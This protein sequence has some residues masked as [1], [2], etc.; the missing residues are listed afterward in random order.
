MVVFGFSGAFK[1][2]VLLASLHSAVAAAANDRPLYVR[3]DKN[4]GHNSKA[5]TAH[6]IRENHLEK[7]CS[8]WL[9]HPSKLAPVTV[10][11]TS[12]KTQKVHTT[13]IVTKTFTI[14]KGTTTVTTDVT[15]TNDAT[16]RVVGTDYVTETDLGYATDVATTTVTSVVGTSTVTSVAAMET[17]V[18]VTGE[19][20]VV[21]TA[22]VTDSTTVT[23]TSTF[24]V[25][26]T[27]GLRAVPAKQRRNHRRRVPDCL[28]H[29]SDDRISEGC[30]S[31]IG[32]PKAGH[33]IT[34][35]IATTNI[36]STH[37]KTHTSFGGHVVIPKE[38]VTVTSTITQ[39]ATNNI[40]A[41]LTTIL[42]TTATLSSTTSTTAPSTVLTTE[43][44]TSTTLLPTITTTTTTTTTTSTP[45][46]TVTVTSTRCPAPPESRI[47]GTDGVQVPDN[48]AP[49]MLQFPDVKGS[50][51]CCLACW[52]PNR[53]E[54]CSAW[55]SGTNYCFLIAAVAG[56]GPTD[57][58][59]AGLGGGV[60][61]FSPGRTDAVGGPGPCAGASFRTLE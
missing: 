61:Y 49:G 54:G 39:Q 40:T 4:W 31:V 44:T 51:E 45:T 2:C 16:D 36:T 20:T 26:P 5:D 11:V 23:S 60:L 25:T 21:V 58:C 57:V 29:S 7:W 9:G 56:P 41:T 33:T 48:N 3:A 24:F 55:A 18:T 34:K 22:T 19:S 12:T 35:V 37:S 6:I 17:V 59:P 27:L 42:T 50:E 30:F 14:T 46:T 15:V 8:T 52:G 43:L 32:G 38:T 28:E 10:L 13:E 47:V 1:A 53:V